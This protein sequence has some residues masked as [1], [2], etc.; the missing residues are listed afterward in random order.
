MELAQ[1]IDHTLLKPTATPADIRKLCSEAREYEFHAVCVNSSHLALAGKELRESEVAIAAVIGFPLGAM[2]STVKV[3]ET[4]FCIDQGAD[5]ID[6]VLN[7]GWLKSGMHEQVKDEI[8]RIKEITGSKILKVIIE[9]CYLSEAEKEAACAIVAS[10]GADFIKTSTG[11]GTGGA[12]FEDVQLMKRLLPESVKI[13]ASG[14][15]KDHV[16][17]RKYLELG[18]SRLGT[19]SGIAIVSE[20]NP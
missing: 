7:I 8:S 4:Q 3:F 20:T 17:A 10:S 16:T 19:S 1:Y 14:G 12:T 2:G 9:S 11:F 15:I 6:M 18:A 13:K 5:E